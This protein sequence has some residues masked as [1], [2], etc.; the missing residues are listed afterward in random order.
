MRIG[1]IG[2]GNMGSALI[3][4]YVYGAAANGKNL[5]PEA[6]FMFDPDSSKTDEIMKKIP[7]RAAQ[8]LAQLVGFTEII[9]VCVKPNIIDTV[10]DELASIGVQG[11]IIVSIAAGVSIGHIASKLG[12]GAKIVRAM[13][14][15][16]AMIGLGMTALSPS[17]SISENE[18]P[19]IEDI[20]TSAGKAVWLPEEHMDIVTGISGSSPA[21]TYMFLEG[22][23]N[24]G[25]ANGL[26]KE[27]ATLLGAQ[28]TMGAAVMVMESADDPET[29]RKNVCSPG[30][31]TIEAVKVLEAD[32][33]IDTVEKAAIAAME[34]SKLMTK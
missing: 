11:K 34:K 29:L 27:A 12:E 31:T 8:S 3:N 25:I 1:F 2:I 10:L 6:V 26:S 7:I 23:I 30:G 20:F 32:G 5:R 24:A 17:D 16:P 13:P 18:Y 15:T 33:F 28:A 9:V 21:Y 4:G 22:L 14:N 19:I